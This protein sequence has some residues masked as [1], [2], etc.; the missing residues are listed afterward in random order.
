MVKIT[1]EPPDHLLRTSEPFRSASKFTKSKQIG[2]E[3]AVARRSRIQRRYT[4]ALGVCLILSAIA[5]ALAVESRFG[6]PLLD[7][8]ALAGAIVSLVIA[9]S[10]R[11]MIYCEDCGAAAAGM[12]S[13]HRFRWCAKC[14]R[15]L[16]P[17]D[18]K[19]QNGRLELARDM[20]LAAQNDAPK[21]LL[22]MM[23]LG[24]CD[25]VD[26]MA[27]APAETDYRLCVR[28]GGC[29]QEFEPPPPRLHCRIIAV[30]KTLFQCVDGAARETSAAL[31]VT[32]DR[33]AALV[34]AEFANSAAGEILHLR[35]DHLQNQ[36][37][38]P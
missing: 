17:L 21:A 22:I 9:W 38:L 13:G 19:P 10:W 20:A 36:E 29:T 6:D 31:T 1:C 2:R 16:M 15:L 3:E 33:G 26:E 28:L 34:S 37:M 8:F 30:A 35:F 23:Y 11:R 27:F 5:T 14:D 18:F 4:A 7:A 25:R 32:T 12:F 24:V